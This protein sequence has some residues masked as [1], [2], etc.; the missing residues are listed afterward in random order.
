MHELEDYSSPL[1]IP[2]EGLLETWTPQEA[3]DRWGFVVAAYCTQDLE[4]TAERLRKSCRQF[5]IPY[6]LRRIEAQEISRPN[7]IYAMLEEWG[8]PILQMDCHLVFMDEPV[9][10]REA[11]RDGC[12]FAVVNMLSAEVIMHFSPLEYDQCTEGHFLFDPWRFFVGGSNCDGLRHLTHEQLIT[13]SAIGLW[14]NTVGARQLLKRWHQELTW[15]GKAI[16]RSQDSADTAGSASLTIADDRILSWI[17]NNRSTLYD[18]DC[19]HIRASWLPLSYSRFPEWLFIEPIINH[20]EFV[21]NKLKIPCPGFSHV[22]PPN[23]RSCTSL[24]TLHHA[25]IY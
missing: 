4:T 15:Y 21:T 23:A 22:H 12:D 13:T 16:A 18:G 6:T 19:E 9:A 11:I 1:P 8:V 5:G 7:F 14:N 20:P 24:V 10:L 3:I 17:W 2:S 25:Y